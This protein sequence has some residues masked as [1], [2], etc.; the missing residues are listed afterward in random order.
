[1]RRRKIFDR[2][3]IAEEVAGGRRGW[4]ILKKNK[5]VEFWRDG[6]SVRT[7]KFVESRGRSERDAGEFHTLLLLWLLCIQYKGKPTWPCELT[8]FRPWAVT[9]INPSPPQAIVSTNSQNFMVAW[10]N[11]KAFDYESRDRR[12]DPCRNH[13]HSLFF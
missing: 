4:S 13:S 7:E 9:R 10:P 11:G 6:E 2:S 3:S 5:G 8:S 1:M 12:F